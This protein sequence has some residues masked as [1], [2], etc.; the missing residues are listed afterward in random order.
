MGCIGSA[1]CE[2]NHELM[3]YLTF[4]PSGKIRSTE[5]TEWLLLR[6]EGLIS[7]FFPF[8][9][10]FNLPVAFGLTI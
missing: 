1:S 9:A 5:R 8:K 4:A 2:R 6:Y 10:F 3:A 7:H